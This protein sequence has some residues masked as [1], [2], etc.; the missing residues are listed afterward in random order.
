MQLELEY[1][2]LCNEDRYPLNQWMIMLGHTYAKS[3][4]IFSVVNK[5][6]KLNDPNS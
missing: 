1:L 5:S 3:K 2:C 6:F 4:S